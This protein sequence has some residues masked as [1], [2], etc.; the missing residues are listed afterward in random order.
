MKKLIIILFS[1]FLLAT[2]ADAGRKHTGEVS[3]EYKRER[4]KTRARNERL[5]RIKYEREQKAARMLAEA[6]MQKAEMLEAGRNR[7]AAAIEAGKEKRH[8]RDYGQGSVKA[9]ETEMEEAGE[10]Q[11]WVDKDGVKHFSNTGAPQDT[12][13]ETFDEIKYR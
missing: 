7:R 3:S 1:V 11:M 5:A 9:K 8:L 6:E 10:M 12:E 13:F 4:D 2:Y